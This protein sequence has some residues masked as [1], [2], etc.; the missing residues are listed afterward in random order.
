MKNSLGKLIALSYVLILA[1]QCLTYAQT[2]LCNQTGGGTGG[3]LTGTLEF[4]LEEYSH[5]TPTDLVGHTGWSE[6]TCRG[7][8]PGDVHY[9]PNF[10]KGG[11]ANVTN[12]SQEIVIEFSPAVADLECQIIGARTVTDNRGYSR[13]RERFKQTRADGCTMCSPSSGSFH[14]NAVTVHLP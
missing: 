2:D 1:M 5:T 10:T 4:I 9:G 7:C 13:L 14:G 8:Y 3:M 11:S 12:Y 6:I